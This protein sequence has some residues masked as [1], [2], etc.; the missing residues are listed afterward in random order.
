MTLTVAV[1]SLCFSHNGSSEKE[2]SGGDPAGGGEGATGRMA[3]HGSI[4]HC[5]R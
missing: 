5:H 1:F 3:A 4:H 2:G